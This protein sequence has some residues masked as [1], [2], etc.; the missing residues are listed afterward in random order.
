MSAADHDHFGPETARAADARFAT[1]RW[2]LVLEAGRGRGAQAEDALARLCRNYWYPLY[3]FVRRRGHPPHD[4]QDLTQEFFARVLAQQT[5]GQADPQRGRF[6]TFM[7]T[8]LT[9]FLAD[10]WEKQR[11][12]KRGGG[13]EI[14]SL[15]LAAAERRF[16]HEPAAPEDAPDRAFDRQWALALLDTV[17]AQLESEYANRGKA[18]LFAALRPALT[19]PRDGQPYA[20][21]ASQLG[22][23]EGAVK[24]A[25][26][27]LRHRYRELV[28]AAIDE[29]VAS[30]KEAA[31]ELQHL[32][33][34]LG[35][36]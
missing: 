29:T 35:E 10:E 12:Q 33:R 19:T 15:D 28:Q 18:A 17:L 22:V 11:A 27:R 9:H 23:S 4:A 14:V 1:T 36:R 6:R 24:V 31:D 25:A 13:R 3:A 8:A 20:E 5:V 30:E 34:A 2:S 32:F 21:I 7:L 16:A 26:H